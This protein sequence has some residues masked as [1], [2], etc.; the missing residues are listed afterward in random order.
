MDIYRSKLPTLLSSFSPCHLNHYWWHFCNNFVDIL[1]LQGLTNFLP[2]F[3]SPHLHVPVACAVS[4]IS[5]IV[6]PSAIA[7]D[8]YIE[9]FQ[10]VSCH[11]TIYLSR[12]LKLHL[13]QAAEHASSPSLE[14]TDRWNVLSAPSAFISRLVCTK[15]VPPW[16]YF[17]KYSIPTLVAPTTPRCEVRFLFCQLPSSVPV[18][19]V[20]T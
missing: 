2:H 18:V 15:S 17:V 7:R 5:P 1:L 13:H 12:N 8:Q 3:S 16:Q 10:W 6:I 9:L 4:A 14:S 20:R 19:S 11:Q